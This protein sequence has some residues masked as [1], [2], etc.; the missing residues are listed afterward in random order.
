MSGVA[1]RV[2]QVDDEDGRQ[3]VDGQDELETG[4]GA[5]QAGQQ[6]RPDDER[7]PPPRRA[8]PPAGGQVEGEGDGQSRRQEQQRE[9]GGEGDAHLRPSPTGREARDE[10]APDQGGREATAEADERIAFVDGPLHEQQ[11]QD[12][13]EQRGP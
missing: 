10:A 6:Q 3:A 13:E 8:E 1:D 5:D 11:E 4:Q 2:G 12:E 9:R 7:G